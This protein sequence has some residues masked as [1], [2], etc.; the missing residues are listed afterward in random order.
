MAESEPNAFLKMHPAPLII[1]EVQ[2]APS[3]KKVK[4]KI[5][6]TPTYLAEQSTQILKTKYN[7]CMLLVTFNNNAWL[8]VSQLVI[9]TL[10]STLTKKLQ[11]F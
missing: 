10:S 11:I 6:E 8:K 5:L 7:A 2:Y 9:D 3:S 1:D 4:R